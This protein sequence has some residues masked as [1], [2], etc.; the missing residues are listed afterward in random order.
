M[1]GPLSERLRAAYPGV[2]VAEAKRTRN[3]F[4]HLIGGPRPEPRRGVGWWDAGCC[5]C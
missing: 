4:V 2:D 3:L 5:A 1:V